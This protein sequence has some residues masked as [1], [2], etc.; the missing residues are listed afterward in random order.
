VYGVMFYVENNTFHVF[1]NKLKVKSNRVN[2]I[3]LGADGFL[4]EH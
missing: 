3:S 2:V 4:S 1:S